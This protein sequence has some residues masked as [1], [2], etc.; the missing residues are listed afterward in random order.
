MVNLATAKPT[1]GSS[2]TRFFNRYEN[3]VDEYE[4]SISLRD[5]GVEAF[6]RFLYKKWFGVQIAGLGNIPGKGSALLFGN[7]SGA[8]PIDGCLLYDGIINLPSGS[9]SGP[10]LSD[11]V[12]VEGTTNRKGR[13]DRLY[14]AGL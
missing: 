12:F 14:S 11:K 1:K 13:A 7:H 5:A 4:V 2:R 10:I 6:V 8:I 3:D 9:A